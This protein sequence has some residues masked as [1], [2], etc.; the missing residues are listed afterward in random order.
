MDEPNYPIE[1]RVAVH[2]ERL[3]QLEEEQL[4]HR[5][6]LHDLE[7]DRAT[8]ML[9]ARRVDDLAV[10][11]KEMGEKIAAIGDGVQALLLSRARG[12]GV[13]T[14]RKRWLDSRRFVI[15]TFV[16]LACGLV[17]AIATLVWL[18]LG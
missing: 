3:D 1:A 18:A 7:A 8:L 2:A 4:R 6:R 17:G 9:L 15:A 11:S 16:A 10:S 5:A 13:E 12:E 14:E